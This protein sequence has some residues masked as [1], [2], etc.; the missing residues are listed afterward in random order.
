MDQNYQFFISQWKMSLSDYESIFSSINIYSILKY[1]K[2]YWNST[3]GRKFSSF[4]ED[5]VK[6][7]VKIVDSKGPDMD[8]Y[9]F[10]QFS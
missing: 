1:L 6:E 5:V 9:I 8:R 10:V 4:E 2:A 3:K 7:V